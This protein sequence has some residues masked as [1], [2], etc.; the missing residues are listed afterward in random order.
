VIG[1]EVDDHADAA[2]VRAGE[3][4]VEVGERAEQG[5]TSQ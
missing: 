2:I 5:S 1:H 4:L 3:H